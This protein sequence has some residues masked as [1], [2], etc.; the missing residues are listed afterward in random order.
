[1]PLAAEFRAKTTKES[2]DRFFADELVSLSVVKQKR[3]GN[4]LL[5]LQAV[6]IVFATLVSLG[7]WRNSAN[8]SLSKTMHTGAWHRDASAFSH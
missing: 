4:K 5:V 7:V 3:L 8:D 6:V 1:M 2:V